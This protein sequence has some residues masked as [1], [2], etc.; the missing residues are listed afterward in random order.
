MKFRKILLLPLLF[1]SLIGFSQV[2]KAVEDSTKQKEEAKK[3][4]PFVSGYYPVGFFDID[5]KYL[6]KYN[7]YE[8]FRLGFG[9][10]T[11]ER[12]FKDFKIGGYAAYGFKDDAYKYSLGGNVRISKKQRLG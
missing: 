9:G 3:R 1:S 12:L 10:V 6:V 7:N 4:S 5:L 2:S 8:S 11:N